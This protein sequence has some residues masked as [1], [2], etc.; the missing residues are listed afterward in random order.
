MNGMQVYTSQE[1][2]GWFYE[3]MRRWPGVRDVMVGVHGISRH[4]DLVGKTL[5]PIARKLRWCLVLPDF[6]KRHF[7]RYQLLLADGKQ[8]R[9]DLALNR[10]LLQL[11]PS[12]VLRLHLFGFSGGAQFCH[13]YAIIHRERVA[14]QVLVS[15]GW[16]LF[17]SL[18]SRYPYGLGGWPRELPER[19]AINDY[20]QLPTLVFVGDQDTTRDRSLRQGAVLDCEQ[21]MNRYE[22]ARRWMHSWQ[23]LA[24]SNVW[25]LNVL[26]GVGHDLSACAQKTRM[27]EIVMDFLQGEAGNAS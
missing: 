15:A 10:W 9:S 3:P 18:K 23:Q 2:R 7:K 8:S 4:V 12:A 5:L 6:D 1:L 13:R 26:R 24:P 25:Q 27:L 22:R 11:W 16:Y 14:S 19:V 20:T 17:P 21:G